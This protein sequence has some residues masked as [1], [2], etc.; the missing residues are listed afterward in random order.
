MNLQTAGILSDAENADKRFL[1]SAHAEL[2]AFFG[3]RSSPSAGM[4]STKR[5]GETKGK[6]V[7][8]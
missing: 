3:Y 7:V 8:G 5:W 1:L 4:D 6:N 2:T